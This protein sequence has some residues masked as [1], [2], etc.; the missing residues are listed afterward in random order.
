ML[1]TYT[2][3]PY[4]GGCSEVRTLITGAQLWRSCTERVEAFNADGTR[5]ATVGILVRRPR[6]RLGR[7]P[8]STGHKFGGY[9]V[10]GWFG[11]IAFETPTAVLLEANGP[12]KAVTA[13][14]TDAGCERASALS[15]PCSRGSPDPGSSCQSADRAA[16]S[17]ARIIGTWSGIRPH[18]ATLN[19]VLEDRLLSSA[20][21]R[22]P[23]Q[24]P[25]SSAAL[26]Q[27]A[28]R[29]VRGTTMPSAQASSATPLARITSRWA[30]TQQGI[31]GS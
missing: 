26:D 15:R 1:A 17:A 24:M 29:R 16:A 5:I 12:R 22:L 30:G 13:R 25:S 14:C 20:I 10:K 2:K 21:C 18:A 19:A 4:D 3:D 27:P 7:R 31:S 9:K 8:G 6:P 11:A 23:G 28:M